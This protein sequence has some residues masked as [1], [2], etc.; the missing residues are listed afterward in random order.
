MPALYA[1]RPFWLLSLVPSLAAAA[2]PALIAW[3]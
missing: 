3:G 1:L 2:G